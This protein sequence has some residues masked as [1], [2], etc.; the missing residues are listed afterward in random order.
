MTLVTMYVL[1]FIIAK[2]DNV[3]SVHILQRPNA[4]NYRLFLHPNNILCI[5]SLSLFLFGVYSCS[6]EEVLS[7][8]S[9]TEHS[10]NRPHAV[11]IICCCDYTTQHTQL[12][13]E[14]YF[15]FLVM[16]ENSPCTV[17]CRDRLSPSLCV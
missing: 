17:V 1:Y 7:A 16:Q 4:V 9:P 14:C 10:H 5:Y 2:A 3:Y 8:V 13:K 11:N 12:Q 6:A 15:S